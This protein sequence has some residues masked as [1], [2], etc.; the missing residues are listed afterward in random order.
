MEPIKIL[1]AAGA[2]LR[3]DRAQWPAR[4]PRDRDEGST[5][6]RIVSFENPILGSHACDQSLKLY[7]DRPAATS[8]FMT[9]DDG[10]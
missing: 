8:C 10:A 7:R 2:P 3:G 1:D 4:G 5:V 9:L 6:L